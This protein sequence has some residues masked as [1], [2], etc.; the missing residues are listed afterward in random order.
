[1]GSEE[2]PEKPIC[3]VCLGAGG[4]WMQTNGNSKQ[5]A[6]KWVDCSTCDGTGRV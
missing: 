3:G 5:T 1:M 6:K 4:E 2:V